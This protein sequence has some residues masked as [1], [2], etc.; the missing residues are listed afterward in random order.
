MAAG[1]TVEAGAVIGARTVLCAGSFVGRDAVIG[2]DCYLHPNSAVLERCSVG[3]RCVLQAG[4]VVGSDG[5][6]YA[7]DGSR[8][9]KIPQKGIVR[10]EDDVEV[11]ANSAIDRATLGETV[12][13]RGTKIDNLVQVGHNVVIGEDS[14]LCGQS[15]IAG[16]S[17]LG[18]R[19]TLAG[20]VGVGDH[21][22]IGDG[23]IATGQAGVIGDLPAGASRSRECRRPRTGSS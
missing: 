3:A 7:W 16:S 21:V 15:G 19:V 10:I 12:I 18:R 4:S 5:F 9:R 13:G 22:T 8:H 14:L 11:G 6:G 20:Q 17:R 1:A 23:T 2:A